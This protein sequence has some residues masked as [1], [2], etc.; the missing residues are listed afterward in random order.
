M[1]Y[2]YHYTYRITNTRA[3]KHYYGSRSSN[4]EP[5]LDLGIKYFSSSSDKEFKLDQKLNPQD[6]KYK[7]IKIFESRKEAIILEI[8]LHHKFNVGIN[9]NFY[10]KVKQTSTGFD[11][12][13]IIMSEAQRKKISDRHKGT[14]MH[15]N[16]KIAISK[17]IKGKSLSNE[18]K[19]KISNSNKKYTKTDIHCAH[20]SESKLGMILALDNLTGK[21]VCIHKDEFYENDTRY[22]GI[23]K[24]KKLNTNKLVRSE[25]KKGK[26]NPNSSIIE[27]Y[28]SNNLKQFTCEGNFS[29]VCKFNKLPE[30]AL[31][32]SYQNFGEPLYNNISISKINLLKNKGY[33]SYKGWYAVKIVN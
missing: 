10:N 33:Y 2:L 7:I 17:A 30:H 23:N 8:K 13:G 1:Q 18:H 27:I 11:N 21:N 14:K 25:N 4:T 28:D 16:T 12:T 26:L 15:D 9:T 3:K 20:I 24:G 32:K 31:K 22:T 6:Y 5:K 29:S 19:E